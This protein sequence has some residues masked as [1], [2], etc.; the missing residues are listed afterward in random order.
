MITIAYFNLI[1]F[2]IK[3]APDKN[4]AGVGVGMGMCLIVD[5][6]IVLIICITLKC[7]LPIM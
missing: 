2:A 6:V 1:K 3:Y 5:I 4:L 7:I